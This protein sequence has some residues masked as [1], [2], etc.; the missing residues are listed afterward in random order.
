MDLDQLALMTE[1]E[2]SSPGHPQHCAV[3]LAYENHP[4]F[5]AAPDYEA[6]STD[7]DDMTFLDHRAHLFRI[8]GLQVESQWRPKSD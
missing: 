5:C 6:L 1:H 7:F 4:V 2:K 3:G 8:P